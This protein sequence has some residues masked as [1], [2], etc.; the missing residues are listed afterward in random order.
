MQEKQEGLPTFLLPVQL[1]PLNP[2]DVEA[3]L[4]A[5]EVAEGHFMSVPEPI[6]HRKKKS[7]QTVKG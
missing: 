2:K 7:V 3:R 1:D 4:T 6:P 5:K